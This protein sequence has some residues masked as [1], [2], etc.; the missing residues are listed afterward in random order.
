MRVHRVYLPSLRP[1]EMTLSGAEAHHLLQVLRVR[2][3]SA[4]CAFDGKGLEADGEVLSAEA[5]G[6]I[7]LRL[8]Q[9]RVSDAEASL[10]VTLAL[11]LLKGDKLSGVVRQ[12]TELGVRGVQLVHTRYA[13]VPKLSANKLERLRR[14]VREAAKQSGRS[15]VPAVAEPVSLTSL[16]KTTEDARLVVAHPRAQLSVRDVP[17]AASLTLLTGPEGGLHDDEVAEL[18]RSGAL[19]VGLGP[20]ILRAETA[21][22]ALAAAL[23]LRA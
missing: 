11:P 7:I 19:V 14:V 6:R 16:L 18:G 5:A 3:G 12:A 15:Y 22:V 23:L 20:R 9:P 17:S 10:N 2:A 13:D 1:G 8:E 4:V 21:P